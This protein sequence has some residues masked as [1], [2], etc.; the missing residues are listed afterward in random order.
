MGFWLRYMHGKKL[1]ARVKQKN[2]CKANLVVQF[3]VY[4]Q[5]LKTDMRFVVTR[6]K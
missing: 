5:V 2:T 1:T 4:M 3:V 6:T